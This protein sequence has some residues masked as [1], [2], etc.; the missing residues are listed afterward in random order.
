MESWLFETERL[1]I[2]QTEDS[3]IDDM[4][5]IY[6]DIE[7]MRYL[8]AEPKA[9]ETKE[10][11]QVIIDRRKAMAQEFG[12]RL[13]GWSVVLKETN[14]VIG[15]VL[16]K[17]LPGRDAKTPSGE[18]EIGWHLG[19]AHWG[20]GYAIEASGACL[21]YGFDKNP[22]LGRVLAC[23]YPENTRSERIMQ[24]LGMSY[25]GESDDYYGVPLSVYQITRESA[26]H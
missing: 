14:Q 20:K 22:E 13:G 1:W 25:L 21:N 24:K 9:I 16:F 26:G 23:F 17:P 12:D 10:E 5:A 2:R 18:I 8:G 15:A 6:S 7:V 3:D 11:I 4:L 19:Q